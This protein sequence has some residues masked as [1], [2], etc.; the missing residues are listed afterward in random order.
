MPPELRFLPNEAGESEG[1]SDAGIETYRADPFPALA[2]ETSQ[3]SRD[4]HDRECCPDQPVRI[5]IERLEVPRDSLPGVDRFAAAAKYCLGGAAEAGGTKEQG[6][7]EQA[8]HVLGRDLIPVL[9][10]ADF[11]TTGL[12]GPCEPGTP[13]H[14]LVKSNGVSHKDNDTAG[15][16]FGIGKSAVYAASDLQTAFYSTVYLEGEERRFLCQ[17]KT[18][19]ISFTD[20]NGRPFRSVGYWGEPAGYLPVSDQALVPDWLRREEIGTT[21]CSIAVRESHDWHR[22][23]LASIVMNFFPAIHRGELEFQ[24]NG[25]SLNA[26]TLSRHFADESLASAIRSSV[27]EDFLFARAMHECITGDDTVLEHLL[28]VEHAGNFR[29]RMLVRDGLPKRLGFVRNG[30]YIC[31]NLAHFRDKFSRFP[32]YR[33]FVGLVEP[34]G[35]EASIW[36]R[37][38]ENPKHDE[39]SPERLVTPS[40]RNRA[41][42]AGQTLARDIRNAIKAAAMPEAREESNLDELSEFFAL[43][44]PRT[45]E[46]VGPRNIETARAEKVTSKRKPRSSKAAPPG[47]DVDGPGGGGNRRGTDPPANPGDGPGHGPGHGGTGGRVARH[48]IILRDVRTVIPRGLDARHRTVFF[49]P[50]GSGN[51]LLSFRAPGLQ[52]PEALATESPSAPVACEEGTRQKVDVRFSI[53]YEGPIEIVSRS[54]SEDSQ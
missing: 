31:D 47:A 49:T 35:D 1:L 17:G 52:K 48:P 8:L 20:E 12:R 33:D 2:R 19:F 3:N 28:A 37:R 53:P 10:I 44:T 13:F 36:L 4:A 40:E 41:A 50:E 42:R 9:R 11:N 46:G 51:V 43:D 7:F 39:F 6:F 24:I 25:L 26:G 16:S 27:E 38:M 34:V 18:K 21:V 45:D 29:L 5:V 32:M 15:G 30:M 22:E 54:A 23:M 14:S